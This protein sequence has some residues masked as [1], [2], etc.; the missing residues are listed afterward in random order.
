MPSL[1]DHLIKEGEFSL[2]NVSKAAEAKAHELALSLM[3]DDHYFA[4]RV[5]AYVERRVSE[6]IGLGKNVSI[7]H[8]KAVTETAYRPAIF[9]PMLAKHNLDTVENFMKDI[10]DIVEE[11][12][13]PYKEKGAQRV[14]ARR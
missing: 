14:H 7:E 3:P 8:Y 4:G 13:K 5:T 9:V 2:D 12:I 1:L 6:E 10:E 11:A